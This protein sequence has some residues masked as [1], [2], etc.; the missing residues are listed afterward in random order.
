MA[1]KKIYYVANARMPGKKAYAIQI[2]K[3]C[4][5]YIELGYD[6]TLVLPSSYTGE[7]LKEFYGLRVDVPTV[8]LPTIVFK[9]YERA[10]FAL[11]AL[12]FMWACRRFFLKK[13]R[14]GEQFLIYTVD[15]DTFSHTLL[16]RYAKTVAEFHSPK[17]ATLLSRYFFKCAKVVATTK[18]IADEL[19]KT[20]GVH[21]VIVEPNGVDEAF[22]N[23]DGS[24][25]GALYVGRLY[26]WKGLGLLPEA[27]KRSGI[28]MRI[29]GGTREEFE[30]VFGPA[31]ALQ[32]ADVPP[33]DV[34]AALK[35]A[36]VLLLIGTATNED[37]NRYTAPMKVFEYLATGK[38]VVVSATE[39]LRSIVPEG[40]V[41]YCRPDDA[42]ALAEGIVAA[43][44][45]PGDAR[46]R[47]AFARE[48][49]WAARA[50]RIMYHFN[51]D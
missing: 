9:D 37:S 17:R 39:S 48:H 46:A 15:M 16:P 29:L 35:T 25:G 20:F 11:M 27:Q 26:A 21:D 47:V 2:A 18:V 51:H 42:Q 10:G 32:F 22:F 23:A 8:A 33:A 6:L 5:A 7:S 36:D 4:E 50:E 38:P 19:S 24:G 31:G 45:E 34:P 30:Q 43:L 12:S 49:T 44:R 13:K 3:M 41:R 40:L 1:L 28:P 14:A